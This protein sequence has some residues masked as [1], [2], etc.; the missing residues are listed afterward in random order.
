M[1]LVVDTNVV[2]SFFKKESVV[3]EIMLSPIIEVY[4][5]KEMFEEIAKY[6][7][8]ICKVAAISS[9][10]FED[11]VKVIREFVTCVERVQYEKEFIKARE[12]LPAH[13]QSDAPFVGLALHLQ[14]PLWSQDKALKRGQLVQ[15]VSTEEL[16]AM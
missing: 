8:R 2:F 3:Q 13:A 11:I 14:I 12:T 7:E 9:P 4:T 10:Y 6:K 16:V 5:P 1:K 15:I